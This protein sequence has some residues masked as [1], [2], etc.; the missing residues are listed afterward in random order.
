MSS[1]HRSPTSRLVAV[2]AIV[3][4][5][6]AG[7][8]YLFIPSASTIAQQP[9]AKAPPAEAIG[10]ANTLSDAFRYSADHVLPAVVSI[11]NES[12]PRMVRRD[13]RPRGGN[14]PQLPP[15]LGE[16]DPLLKRFFEQMPEGFDNSSG[17]ALWLRP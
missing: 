16:L 1:L 4:S 15:E 5:S 3:L 6:V 2:A 11:R 17:P 8:G 13:A 10:Q 14:R 12:R 7:A 9:A